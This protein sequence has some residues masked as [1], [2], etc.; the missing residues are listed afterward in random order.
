MNTESAAGRREVD[1]RRPP[2]TDD[3]LQ[4]HVRAGEKHLLPEATGKRLLASFDN[5]CHRCGGMSV[6]RTP[7]NGLS[8]GSDRRKGWRMR[9]GRRSA[10]AV[11]AIA[12][13]V[14]LV[15]ACGGGSDSESGK[16]G[17]LH[18]LIGANPQFAKEL[19]AWMKDFKAQFKTK[20]GADVVFETY[21]DAA[22][23][24]TKIQKSLVSGTG[25]DVYSLGT[26]FTPV[27]YSTRGF[28]KLSDED[29]KKVGGRERFI[30]ESLAMSGPDEKNQIG[31][32]AAIRP[33]GLA[34][35]KKLFTAAGIKKPPT[36]WDQL[37]EDAKKLTRPS[38]GVYGL[39]LDY[40]DGFDPWK[41]IWSLTEQSGGSFVSDDLTKAQLDSPQVL[42]ATTGY[43]DLLTKHKLADPKSVGWEA[44][45]AVAA[46][47]GGKAAILPMV[48][49]TLIQ[50]LDTSSVKDEYAFA[51]MPQVPFGMTERPA[52]GVA[53]G[54]IV[55]GDN[56]AVASYS[57]HK[58]LALAYIEL[59]TS[60]DQQ[61]KQQKLLGNLPSNKEAAA[62]LADSDPRIAAFLEAEKI[63]VPTAFVG[64][65]ADVQNGLTNVVTQSLPVLAKGTSDPTAVQALLN[66]ANASVQSALDRE[67]K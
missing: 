12:T 37:V 16:G 48:T 21:A 31:V 59:V 57:K 46:F 39:A 65:W 36:T 53:A 22:E 38:A 42:R 9:Q 44:S 52:G 61:I 24:T 4:V 66:E 18:V 2:A 40:A 8:K 17:K 14:M 45:N 51:P 67:K 19:A 27:A 15:S 23:E 20:T 62:E 32:P 55:S 35:N 50:S 34:Y 43:F 3:I 1:S 7:K 58:D 54:S 10:F 25:P 29:W 5:A 63:S 6:E 11:A 26:T 30:P 47:G 49:P 13:A 28:V 60:K 41:Y 33:F 64:A 56:V